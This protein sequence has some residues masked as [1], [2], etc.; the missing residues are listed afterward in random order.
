MGPSLNACQ[1]ESLSLKTISIGVNAPQSSVG[2][3]CGE[4]SWLQQKAV[5][6]E[7]KESLNPSLGRWKVVLRREEA[8]GLPLFFLWESQKN[9][10]CFYLPLQGGILLLFRFF[11]PICCSFW[12]VLYVLEACVGKNFW[13]GMILGCLFFFLRLC[14]DM[15]LFSLTALEDWIRSFILI[16]QTF[17]PVLS[18][19]ADL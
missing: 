1:A 18:I 4:C 3:S 16:A 12:I 17:L 13:P 7:A 6:G 2:E 10:Y 8:E 11:C 19:K 14:F 5:C 9:L 15:P